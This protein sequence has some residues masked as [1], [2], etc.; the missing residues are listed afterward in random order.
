MVKFDDISE[1][2]QKNLTEWLDGEDIKLVT[3]GEKA[4]TADIISDA[5]KNA[6]GRTVVIAVDNRYALA[7][8][9][10]ARAD[11]KSFYEGIET[12]GES[13]FSKKQL[14]DIVRGAGVKEDSIQMYYPYPDMH[15]TLALYSDDYLPKKGELTNN[16][17]NFGCERLLTFD[18]S[19]AWDRIIEDGEFDRFSNSYLCVIGGDRHT[20]PVFVKYS[21]DRDARYNICT[22]IH[23][24]KQVTKRA[25]GDESI[26]HIEGIVEAYG[27]LQE[28]YRDFEKNYGIRISFNRCHEKARGVAEFEYI[29]GRSL[30]DVLL[31]LADQKEYKRIEELVKLF[32]AMVRYN[33]SASIENI[34][35]IFKNI[36]VTDE[37]WTIID[38]EWTTK[39]VN[40]TKEGLSDY[41]IQRAVYYFLSDNRRDDLINL[42]LYEAAGV[43]EPELPTRC[44][45]RDCEREK[46]FQA[47]V[48]GEH[49]PLGELYDRLGGRIFYVNEMIDSLRMQEHMED[50]SVIDRKAAITRHG[51]LYVLDIDMQGESGVTICPANSQ[52]FVNVRSV[53][54]QCSIKTNGR[55]I[56]N[57]LYAFDTNEPQMVLETGKAAGSIRVEMLVGLHKDGT[58]PVFESVYNAVTQPKTA[59]AGAVRSI[60]NRG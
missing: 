34:D 2:L 57:H 25:T 56:T 8:F 41:I 38:Y 37:E 3:A 7:G 4:V 42:K 18:E 59:I 55:K 15:L 60:M 1:Y 44:Y 50:V 43:S 23:S 10:G 52:C 53:S 20:R 14:I 6:G 45:E 35:L 13:L 19:R 33:N 39:S 17:R 27:M 36:F 54:V 12:E 32:A 40:V 16:F 48:R 26:Q 21:N 47:A 24:R 22:E 46:E 28:R 31:T 51:E 29:D 5:V 58:S 30:E 9:A 11:G 49:Q